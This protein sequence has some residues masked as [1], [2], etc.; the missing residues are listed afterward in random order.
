MCTHFPLLYFLFYCYLNNAIFVYTN[1]FGLSEGED[2][3]NAYA[4]VAITFCSY[5][6]FIL[7]NK[8]Q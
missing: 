6:S 8:L 1:I 7:S 3:F 2:N 5:S 4:Y